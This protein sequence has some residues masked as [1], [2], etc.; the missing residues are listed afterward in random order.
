M[1]DNT[2]KKYCMIIPTRK[3]GWLWPKTK[4]K[5]DK[6]KDEVPEKTHPKKDPKKQRRHFI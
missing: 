1:Y 6:G 3:G 2:N 4:K 5:E